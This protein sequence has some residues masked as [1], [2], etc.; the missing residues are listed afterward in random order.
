MN[1]FMIIFICIALNEY[2]KCKR[3]SNILFSA[4]FIE[5]V[6]TLNLRKFLHVTLDTFSRNELSPKIEE[7]ILTTQ[8]Y[9]NFFFLNES[10]LACAN[11]DGAG[12]ASIYPIIFYDS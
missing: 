5:G 8:R 4:R 9:G 12:K 11:I 7:N 1:L 2:I 3:Q 6:V 10:W